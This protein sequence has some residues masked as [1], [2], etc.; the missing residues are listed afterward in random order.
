[1]STAP[2][3]VLV[4]VD[5]PGMPGDDLIAGVRS[6]VDAFVGWAKGAVGDVPFGVALA[7][8]DEAWT[9][10]H[11]AGLPGPGEVELEPEDEDPEGR[12]AEVGGLLFDRAPPGLRWVVQLRPERD[13]D[14]PEDPLISMVCRAVPPGL[15]FPDRLRGRLEPVLSMG[16]FR[17]RWTAELA[18]V[19]LPAPVR[20]PV[21]AGPDD[22]RHAVLATS[23]TGTRHLSGGGGCD[24]ACGWRTFPGG[25][26]LAVA[27][28]AGFAPRSAEGAARAVQAVLDAAV[29]P[30][31][32]D[33]GEHLQLALEL[34]REE[35][36]ADE[37][38]GELSTTLL[39]AVWT[40][41][42]VGTVQ[43]GDGA[44]VARTDRTLAALT[45][46]DHG[47]YYNE[48]VFV[49]SDDALERAQIEVAEGA[50]TD[51][52]LLTDGLQG[53][54]L[55]LAANRPVP[56]F[57]DPFFNLAQEADNAAATDKLARFLASPR[58]CARTDDD[59]TLVV[60]SRK[61]P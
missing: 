37:R 54:A 46:P 34:A 16:A 19:V 7:E 36:L 24:D 8:D 39:L 52:A 32:D 59:K 18:D 31:E 41:D 61:A 43:V 50:Y 23:V 35:L 58:V 27:D 47:E 44:I 48:T 5:L 13:P 21:S 6:V 49:V 15:P 22:G 57:F 33:W 51:L 30:P 14:D 1:M 10:L 17:Q 28:G 2:A 26:A 9:L 29:P 60:A 20:A 56:G 3:G 38:P 11:W 42:R 55:E 25:V 53:L 12:L 4:L 45:R 40:A